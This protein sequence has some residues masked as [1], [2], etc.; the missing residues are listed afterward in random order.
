MS[1]CKV[2]FKRGRHYLWCDTCCIDKSSSAEL[3]E[4]VNS[5]YE[6]YAQ[7]SLCIAYLDDIEDDLSDD[8]DL[9][10]A[11]WFSRGS[12]STL[13]RQTS[14]ASD[15]DEDILRRTFSFDCVCVSKKIEDQAYSLMGLFGVYMP[16]LYGEGAENAIRRLQLE[17]LQRTN[18]HTIFTW[19]STDAIDD[20]VSTFHDGNP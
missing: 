9:S 5:M 7:S 18:D 8:V 13:S 12:K 3:S 17:I 19:D 1:S 16:P 20:M 2:A 11:A 10:R 15:I 4:A 6:Y 14:L